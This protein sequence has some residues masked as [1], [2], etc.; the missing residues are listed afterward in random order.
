MYIANHYVRIDGVTY[1]R[2]ETLPA[3]P[4]DVRDR[5]LEKGAI[6]ALPDEPAG[7]T[8]P[9]ETEIPADDT[10]PAPEAEK[11]D[12]AEEAIEID[13]ADAVVPKP[14]PKKSRPKKGGKA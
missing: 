8:A 10:P 3:L 14:A 2:G 4:P 7:E 13:A 6:R 11:A 12:G 5:L 1:T 9:H